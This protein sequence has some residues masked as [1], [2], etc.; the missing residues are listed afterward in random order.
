MIGQQRLGACGEVQIVAL[1]R[2]R[3][4]E[5]L[6][7][8][9]LQ[10][11]CDMLAKVSKCHQKA[12]V[13]PYR[14]ERGRRREQPAASLPQEVEGKRHHRQFELDD[15][16]T[17]IADWRGVRRRTKRELYRNRV[18]QRQR[19]RARGHTNQEAAASLMRGAEQ[20]KTVVAPSFV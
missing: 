15:V 5:G 19:V 11:F 7:R 14:V 2:S 16:V 10:L 3:H 18:D 17:T 12:F 4:A 20:R 9:R 8:E 1:A 6:A 13:E